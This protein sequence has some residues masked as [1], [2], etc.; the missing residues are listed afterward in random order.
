MT[1]P[2]AETLAR[3]LSDSP[4]DS[5]AVEAHLTV[6]PTCRGVLDDLTDSHDLHPWLARAM[7]LVEQPA[8]TVL[9]ELLRELE[10]GQTREENG[11][12]GA[13]D[14]WQLRAGFDQYRIE[15]EI[16]RGGMGVVFRA[17]D[18][19]LGRTVAIKVL[20]ADWTD[21]KARARLIRE[22]RT[23]ANLRHDNVVT[24]YAVVNPGDAAPYL[25]MEHVQG[26]TLAALIR[27]RGMLEA[28]RAA[29]V[30]VHVARALEAAHDQGL[31]HRDVK[32]SNVLIESASGRAKLSDF[33]LARSGDGDGSMTQEG[34]L[35]GTPTF[36]SPEQ[37]SGMRLDRRA[38]VYSLGATLY[39]ALTGE[40][41]FRGAP[42]MVFQ[43]VTSEEPRPPRAL[44][45][46]IP[47][48]LETICLKAMSKEP[49]R[50]YQTAAEF[51]DDLLRWQRGEPI[52][53][54]PVGNLE[55][56]WRWCR[57]RPIIAALVTALVLVMAAGFASTMLQWRRAERERDAALKDRARA[58][59]NFRQAREAVDTYLTQVSESDVL[60]SQNLEPL[61]RELLR[62]ARD[63]YERFVQQDP[64]NRSLQFALGLAHERLGLITSLLESR[65][66]AL[67]H[68]QKMC[69]I[70]E[71]LH[72][73]FPD[74]P[75]F[76]RELAV[77]YFRA[78][79]CRRADGGQQPFE[80][81]DLFT[82]ARTLQQ[83]LVDVHPDEPAYRVDLARTLRSLGNFYLFMKNDQAAAEQ[84]LLA[85]RATLDHAG[86]ANPEGPAAENERGL[87]FLNLAKVYAHSD[88]P[89]EQRTAAQRAAARFEP[90]VAAH[91]GN[92]DY[93][94]SLVDASN[95]LGDA[96]RMLAQ[97]D[98]ARAT[99]QKALGLAEGLA[100]SH[101]ANG[102]FRH[103]V[104]DIAYSLASL[105]Y[106][107][108]GQPSEARPLLE[109][110]LEIE[111]NLALSFPTVAEYGY[112]WAILLRDFRDWFGDTGPALV[113][114]DRLNS[115]IAELERE[116]RSHPE[117]LDRDRLAIYV[118]GLMYVDFL[119]GRYQDAEADARRAVALGL[120]YHPRE[121][122]RV[123][124]LAEQGNYRGADAETA[125]V[126]ASNAGNGTILYQLA[127]TSASLV[128]I[129]GNDRSLST[130]KKQ[131]LG[132]KFGKQAVDSLRKSR[133]LK[134]L[135]SPFTR[136]LLADDRELDPIRDRADFRELLTAH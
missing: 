31:I 84:T 85:A 114:R 95:E 99:W 97:T 73:A 4:A 72:N 102:Y 78:A 126:A 65:P 96:Q 17:T 118:S 22:A 34:F 122:T 35:A 62:T 101:S 77:G 125:A 9:S 89:E 42:H 109:Q 27:S 74:E 104:A 46:R 32:P 12:A 70:F 92:P 1:C 82:R 16:G 64:G 13:E 110:A 57:R 81:R 132:E 25:V 30:I 129:V 66:N 120:D 47:R 128:K 127:Q 100:R 19:T 60:K 131:E 8:D 80:A 39:E 40:A 98:R 75:L 54:R 133:A 6:C 37:A 121:L 112:Y 59:H 135:S 103:F 41:P 53:A 14:G 111:E 28:G 48:D 134:Y 94:F 26:T 87:V 7:T 20:R 69:A 44:F 51:A 115:L 63:F 2:S 91:E 36:M 119:L 86:Q 18:L 106:H 52:R 107:E 49:A 58:E 55:R 61:R 113:W 23:A 105:A 68:Y 11:K 116:A 90:L 21:E 29:D 24:V 33:G 117:E 67:E 3:F 83:A 45:D 123:F 71:P 130:A 88:R 79:E 56:T 15:G 5:A 124:L 76:Q 93:L 43:Q 108:R 38:D 136:W 10:S 50:R